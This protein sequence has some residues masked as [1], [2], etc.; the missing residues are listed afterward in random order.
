MSFGINKEEKVRTRGLH[1]VP[2]YF[3]RKILTCKREL[4]SDG[5]NLYTEKC[6]TQNTAR[7]DS[8]FL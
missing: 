4:F 5:I 6:D 3:I 7:R 8:K 1:L 2:W